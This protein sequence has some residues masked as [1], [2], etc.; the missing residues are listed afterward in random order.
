M[1][2]CLLFLVFVSVAFAQDASVTQMRSLL[3]DVGVRQIDQRSE[4]QQKWE[5][6]THELGRPG[7]GDREAAC[8]AMAEMLDSSERP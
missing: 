7:N 5:K 2:V 8:L 3:S 1:R 4:A 6:L